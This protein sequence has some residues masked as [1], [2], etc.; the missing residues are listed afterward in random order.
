MTEQD[1]SARLASAYKR[2]IESAQVLGAATD[3]FSKPIIQIDAALKK[4]DLGLLTWHK[5]WGE[6]D[7]FGNFSHRDIG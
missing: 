7:A 6:E 2:L 4:L 5:V 3:E 1:R